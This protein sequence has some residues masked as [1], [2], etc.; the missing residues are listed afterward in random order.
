MDKY[1]NN[2]ITEFQIDVAR[3]H[4]YRPAFKELM[5]SISEII[6]V[7][8]PS[9]SEFGNPDF[10]FFN[11]TN[12]D[13]IIGYAETKDITLLLDTFENS[14][15]LKRYL[16]YSN[17]ILTNYID[18]RFFTNGVK[19]T[20][21]EIAKI[22]AGNLTPIPGNFKLLESELKNFL[23]SKPE[24]IKSGKR[25]AEIMG[26]KA[27]RIRENIKIFMRQNENKKNSELIKIFN[28][29]RQLLVHDLDID[30][31]ADM[32]SQTL[33]YGLFVARYHD[34]SPESFTRQEARDLIPS[35]N[36]FL[37]RFFDHIAGTQFDPRLRYIVDELCGIFAIADVKNILQEHFNLF[38]ESSNKD[39]IIHFYEDF[40][41]EYDAEQ[42]KSMGA[43][44]TPLPVVKFIIKS[45][46]MILKS[47]FQLSKG[48]ADTTLIKQEVKVQGTKM[49]ASA[50]KVQV[51]DPAVG[52]AT[53]LNEIIKFIYQKNFIGQEG[54][55]SSYVNQ[56]LLPRL[57]GFELMMAPYTIAH[58]KLSATL[59][60]RGFTDFNKRLGVYLTNTLEEGIK[61]QEDL[62]TE[63]GLMESITDEARTAAKIKHES[64]IMVIVGNPP[65]S[66]ESNNKG[67]FQKELDVYKTEPSGGRLN[68]RNSK[69]INDDYVKFIRFAESTI[70]KN[71]EGILAYITNHSYID[72]P[73][74]RGMRWHLLQ[75]FDEIYIVDL[76]GNYKRNETAL[77]GSKD[78]NIF[79][80]IQG[81][82]IIIGVKK[83]KKKEGLSKLFKAD[84]LGTT[85][86]KFDFLNSSSLENI[87]WETIELHPPQYEFINV[88]RKN[89]PQYLKGFILSELFIKSSVGLVSARD[90]MS[91]QLSREKIDL[92]INDFRNLDPETLRSK[93]K[94]GKDVRDWTVSGAINDIN[95]HDGDITK[96]S[97]R[98]FDN[99]YT[100]YTGYSRGFHCYPRNE[101][102]K[103]YLGISN[104][105]LVTTRQQKA[106][107][108]KPALV[109]SNIVES[110]FVSNKTSEISYDF[111]LFLYENGEKIS[112]IDPQIQKKIEIAVKNKVSSVEIFDYVYA[113]LYCKQYQVKY[114]DFLRN[115]FPVIPYPSDIDRFN[116][117]SNQGKKLRLVHLFAS[118]D[119]DQFETTFNVRGTNVVEFAKYVEEKIF[120]NETQ[121][122]GNI[123]SEVWNYEIG[124]YKPAYNWLKN[125]INEKISDDEI[126]DYQKLLKAQKIS[127]D[128]AN[129]LETVMF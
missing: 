94:L 114:K 62:F 107:K 122:F 63:L 46:D 65:Y 71:G 58:L 78:E 29:L 73:T 106:T 123:G 90:K 89:N 59:R 11:K 109:H 83:N 8:D 125:R 75:T 64:P 31:F 115:G 52:T 44:Y 10:I 82:A 108:I 4:A 57:F 42:R 13:I 91:M 76:H 38:G 12:K 43:Y 32:Y 54:A 70:E 119:T 69:W 53:F 22:N 35:S 55:W 121:Y 102:M 116:F 25:L 88:N 23:L 66:G 60:E 56:S 39:P 74:F 81:V 37:Q 110:T 79:G 103:N 68:E 127:I 34:D 51:L 93:Y 105:G 98:P 111:P 120:I 99:R 61:M 33:V 5:E 77:D 30:K 9:R 49:K 87:S 19:R 112:N 126:I 67:L 97:Y 36:P 17:L 86:E 113:T 47:D 72:N 48:L 45:V 92:V 96:I 104:Y 24:R 50:Y 7:N 101:I 15:Q 129:T 84:V 118:E 117:L 124:S 41:K 20:S 18:F 16:G 2:L 80:I 85:K 1:I 6:A 95:E 27:L 3:E 100:Y 14:K 28:V 128:I 26:G 21:I 40:L